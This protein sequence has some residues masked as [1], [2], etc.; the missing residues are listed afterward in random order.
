MPH[1]ASYADFFSFAHTRSL[2]GAWSHHFNKQQ[3]Q[4]TILS[5]VTRCF[6][7]IALFRDERI[8]SALSNI[9]Y[10]W[11]TLHPTIGYRQ[12]MHE[13]A[14]ALYITRWADSMCSGRTPLENLMDEVYIEHDTYAI[15]FKL[16]E[17]LCELY[18]WQ[19]PDSQG[20]S[21][22]K[23][24]IIHRS[25]RVFN[26][27]KSVDPVLSAQL[28]SLSIEP[29][30]FLLRWMRLLFLREFP[31]GHALE[32]WDS[33]FAVSVRRQQQ[34]ERRPSMIM[35]LVD[36]T[37]IA[38]LL[39]LR[40]RLLVDSQTLVLGTLLHPAPDRPGEGQNNEEALSPSSSPSSS[41]SI[42]AQ[43]PGTAPHHTPLLILQARQ[44][45]CAPIASPQLGVQV[46]MQNAH[47]LGIPVHA[48]AAPSPSPR[49]PTHA[50][51][52]GYGRQPRSR[53][54]SPS[55]SLPSP[56]TS[57]NGLSDMARALYARSGADEFI[58][59]ASQQSSS[60]LVTWGRGWVGNYLAGARP[61]R[62]VVNASGGF[63]DRLTQLERDRR[64][65]RLVRPASP[66]IRPA[67]HHAP[68]QVDLLRAQ[69]RR[70]GVALQDV[71]ATFERR[72]LGQEEDDADGEVKSL[73]ALTALRH[74][75]DL[76]LEGGGEL[77]E[78]VVDDSRVGDRSV[79][80]SADRSLE[81]VETTH[82][83]SPSSESSTPPAQVLPSVGH[84]DSKHSSAP[85][86]TNEQDY[87]SP[88]PSAPATFISVDTTSASQVTNNQT[89]S[90]L[91]STTTHSTLPLQPV[92]DPLGALK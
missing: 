23:P 37:C 64:E 29:Q 59:T 12:G 15:F 46:V 28:M 74:V 13:L 4:K 61:P 18:E 22:W 55:P 32:L 21:A 53:L 33:L 43:A 49:S 78:G 31:L 84:G 63:P 26:Y 50:Q 27:L 58:S 88:A 9:L 73:R 51:T 34:D 19:S 62:D 14:G 24:P 11:S 72:W 30:L 44:F 67:L 40:N 35:D 17:S 54:A 71:V 52:T 20:T 56:L 68:S 5:D 1:K 25:N 69:N 80:E 10:V 76:L 86:I 79:V 87:T 36:W 38:Y 75:R 2:Q 16:M 66:S 83:S 91:K 65:A 48:K 92:E 39:R 57:S 41:R 70:L 90:T 77:E 81:I 42:P 85:I 3:L 8:Q 7:D 6:P 45:H 60:D 47:L 82:R 89:H